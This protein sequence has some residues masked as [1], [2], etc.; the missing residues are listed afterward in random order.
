MAKRTNNVL[1]SIT[2][3]TNP[4]V[5]WYF[6]PYGILTPHLYGIFTLL[7]SNQEIGKLPWEGGSIYHGQGSQNTMDRGVKIPWVGGSKYHGQG[8]RYTMGKGVDIQWVGGSKYHGQGVQYILWVGGNK[9]SKFQK[10]ISIFKKF[11]NFN[12]KI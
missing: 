5:I 12:K 7:I 3:I 8:G 6:D 10:K 1:Q 11:Q 4:N 2:Q 9:I